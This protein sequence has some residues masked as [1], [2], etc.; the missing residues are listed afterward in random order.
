[1]ASDTQVAR[2]T[3]VI[4]VTRKTYFAPYD[5][6]ETAVVTLVQSAKSK[7]RLADYSYNL[8]NLTQALIEAHKNGIDVS[9]VLDRSQSAGSTE[10]PRIV[11]LASAGVPMVI[12]TSSE[13]KI[14][15]SKFIVVDDTVVASGSYNFTGTAE[16]ED[17]FLDIEHSVER[18]KA[19]TDNWQR[20]HDYIETNNKGV[21][22][23]TTVS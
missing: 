15:H 3:Q 12:G 11:E 21:S 20:M 7:I 1:V 14:M 22:H 5:D 10:K 16:H 4:D 18:A 23:A 8:E 2:T 19:F 17:N 13:H 9:L 6:A